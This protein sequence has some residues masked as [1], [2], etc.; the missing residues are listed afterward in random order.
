MM[1]SQSSARMPIDAY[2]DGAWQPL[3]F[4][5]ETPVYPCRV[6]AAEGLLASAWLSMH[7]DHGAY[8]EAN[9]MQV[10]TPHFISQEE[11]PVLLLTREGVLVEQPLAL[12]VPVVVDL[13][14]P[15]A[16]LPRKWADL[17]LQHGTDDFPEFQAWWEPLYDNEDVAPVFAWSSQ[18]A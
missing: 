2:V 8:E 18:R 17:V 13:L 1:R 16:L 4:A 7:T 11:A 3:E 10:I 9:R 12:G 5:N 14:A 6:G 15:H